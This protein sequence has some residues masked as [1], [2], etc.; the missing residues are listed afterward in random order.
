MH[1]DKNYGGNINHISV[2]YHVCRLILVPSCRFS[3]PDPAKLKEA[4][5]KRLKEIKMNAVL[6]EIAAF[7]IFLVLLI[8]VAFH[9]RDTNTF[10]LTKT[11]HE[12]F[13]EVDA[14]SIGL[15]AVSCLTNV[16][17]LFCY[18]LNVIILIDISVDFSFFCFKFFSLFS[19]VRFS[20]NR[21]LS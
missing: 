4:R 20:K 17:S 15:A 3:P 14:Y 18:S 10:L 5:A 21:G 12:T 19:N 9:H 2:I 7:Y 13:E 8:M 11:L 16:I 6:K 1:T